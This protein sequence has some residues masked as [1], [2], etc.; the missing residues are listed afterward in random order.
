M[1]T[2]KYDEHDDDDDDDDDNA[3]NVDHDDHYDNGDHHNDI[4]N[5]NSL[6]AGHATLY[7]TCFERTQPCCVLLFSDDSYLCLLALV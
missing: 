7:E 3:D 2:I 5:C 1:M 4:S 6:Y